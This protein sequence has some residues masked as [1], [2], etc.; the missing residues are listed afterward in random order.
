MPTRCSQ[1][2]CRASG[3]WYGHDIVHNYVPLQCERLGVQESSLT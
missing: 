2:K 1:T 3:A